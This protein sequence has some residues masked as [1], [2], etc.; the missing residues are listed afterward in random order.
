MSGRCLLACRR[1][2]AAIL[3]DHVCV[4]AGAIQISLVRAETDIGWPRPEP[5]SVFR[6]ELKKVNGFERDDEIMVE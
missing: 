3:R 6:D 5:W 2:T 1:Y 4:R